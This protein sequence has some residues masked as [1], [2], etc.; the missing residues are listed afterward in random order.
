MK[1]RRRKTKRLKPIQKF[2]AGASLIIAVLVIAIIITAANSGNRQEPDS[3]ATTAPATAVP[4]E[5]T[6]HYINGVGVTA[7][8]STDEVAAC[9]TYALSALMGYLKI[10]FDV[11]DFGEN[12]LIKSPISYDDDFNRYGPDMYTAF[13][14]DLEEG[15][16][17]YAPAMTSSINSFLSAKGRSER[18]SDIYGKTLEELCRE[19]IDRDIPVMIWANAY[20]Q[21]PEEYVTW[22]VDTVDE[23]ARTKKGEL[24]EWPCNE[25]CMLLIGYDEDSYFL[26]DSVAGEISEFDREDSEKS[27]AGFGRQAIVIQ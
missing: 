10:D 6:S 22:I 27:Y 7:Q 21:E 24:F 4:A 9:E 16:G 14:G 5:K 23:N 26:S 17:I 3:E 19:Y 12:Y 2:V 15:Y 8:G 11:K 13:A 20:M 18:A 1:K 25:H